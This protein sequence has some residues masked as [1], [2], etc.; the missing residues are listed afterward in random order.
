[1]QKIHAK[2]SIVNPINGY[3]HASELIESV[4]GIAKVFDDQKF[5]F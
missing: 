4:S 3:L 2:K 5:L 1:M